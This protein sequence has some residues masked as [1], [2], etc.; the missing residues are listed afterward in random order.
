MGFDTDSVSDFTTPNR[1]NFQDLTKRDHTL[2][3]DISN[4]TATE[5]IHGTAEVGDTTKSSNILPASLLSPRTLPPNPSPSESLKTP[6]PGPKPRN[7]NNSAA[8][9]SPSQTSFLYLAIPSPPITTHNNEIP[10]SSNHPSA[11]SATSTSRPADMTIRKSSPNTNPKASSLAT[12][13]IINISSSD[14]EKAKR[15][16]I[17]A[18]SALL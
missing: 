5:S 18:L 10:G 14:D 1:S 9:S 8:A 3:T 2:P 17:I 13:A 7:T 4:F 15:K 11:V 16:L 12:S 6:K